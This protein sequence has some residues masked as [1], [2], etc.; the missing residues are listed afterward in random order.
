MADLGWGYA[1]QTSQPGAI[2][3]LYDHFCANNN[4]AN[5]CP[6]YEYNHYVSAGDGI[7]HPEWKVQGAPS[8]LDCQPGMIRVFRILERP[9][10]DAGPVHTYKVVREPEQQSWAWNEPLGCLWPM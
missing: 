8:V 10:G 7:Y 9:E 4:A 2:Y 3:P 5:K 1:D 6:G